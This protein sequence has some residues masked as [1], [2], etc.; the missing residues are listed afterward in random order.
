[1]LDIKTRKA[2]NNFWEGKHKNAFLREFDRLYIT[3]VCGFITGVSFGIA[4]KAAIYAL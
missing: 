4:I 1:M 3:L 2:V